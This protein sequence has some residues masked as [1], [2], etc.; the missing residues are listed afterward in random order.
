MAYG[1][2]IGTFFIMNRSMRRVAFG[3]KIIEKNRRL[4]ERFTI[5]IRKTA[6]C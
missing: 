6:L 2:A 5:S 1:H 3:L 4:K